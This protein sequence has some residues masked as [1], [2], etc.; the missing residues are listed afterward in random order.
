M[1]VELSKLSLNPCRDFQIDPIDPEAIERL[2]ESINEHGFWGGVVV[3][4]TADGVMEVV[5]GHHRIHAAIAEGV[6]SAELPV[7]KNADVDTKIAIYGTENATQRGNT[8]N[9]RVGTVAAV[10]KVLAERHLSETSSGTGIRSAL[11]CDG[12]LMNGKGIGQPAVLEYLNEKKIPGH[13]VRTVNEDLANLRK[14]GDFT[15]I[16]EEVEADLIRQAKEAEEEAAR[17]EEERKVAEEQGRVKE[18]EAKAKEEAKAKAKAK[19]KGKASAKA[20]K[21]SK[22]TAAHNPKVF[23]YRGVSK[24]LKNADHIEAFRSTVTK[25]GIAELLPVDKQSE[26]A[27]A[28]VKE[29]E[30]L[31]KTQQG[32]KT[33][34]SGQFIREG[35]VRLVVDARRF[36][37]AVN[38]DVK[39]KAIAA[40]TERRF[41]ERQHAASGYLRSFFKVCTQITEEMAD[42]PKG[43]PVP[44]T[45]EFR[46]TV[47]TAKKVI[48]SLYER[49]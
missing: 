32:K 3:N 41:K 4:Q 30:E 6:K 23:D 25:K 19:A 12:L 20:S 35:I 33:E 9:A 47:A 13:S 42:W 36:Q 46:D 1:L 14:S 21:A 11:T 8:S 38:K 15:R 45:G 16:I 48:D 34:L 39:E 40:E 18:A 17:L 5:C 10:V 44:I 22:A 24:H 27:A 31:R 2:R 26:L 29:V 37:T 7:I 43:H 28:L 49:I